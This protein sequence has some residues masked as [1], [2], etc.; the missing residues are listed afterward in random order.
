MQL[1][2]TVIGD[3]VN[4]AA[5]LESLAEQNQGEAVFV[6]DEVAMHVKGS[7]LLPQGDVQVK[8]RN[9]AIRVFRW[10]PPPP[11]PAL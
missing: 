3:A 11:V 4:A 10:V 5:R 8:G 1:D 9:K 7:S 2:S 6:S